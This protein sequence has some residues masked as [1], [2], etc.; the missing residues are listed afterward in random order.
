MIEKPAVR[1]MIAVGLPLACALLVEQ[2]PKPRVAQVPFS[3]QVAG[4]TLPAGN[5]SVEQF[6]L[7]RGIRLQNNQ[8]AA[9]AQCIAARRK[10]GRTQAARLVF[11]RS[12]GAYRLAEVWLEADGRGM[13]LR[14]PSGRPETKSVSLE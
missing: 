3:F 14:E 8:L 4:E 5:Y 13:I 2:L 1:L 11:D 12:D 7:G 10:F 6:G 9:G